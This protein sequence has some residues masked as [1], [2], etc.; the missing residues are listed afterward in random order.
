MPRRS[1]RPPSRRR[2][3]GW[4]DRYL[5]EVKQRF[6]NEAEPKRGWAVTLLWTSETPTAESVRC[7]VLGAIYRAC[8][9]RKHGSPRTLGQMMEQEGFAAL[10]AGVSPSLA[11]DQLAAAR[12]VIDR[13]R[14]SPHL[15]VQ[16]ACL[17]GDEAAR[18]VG[19]PPLGLPSR[20]GF[21]LAIAEAAQRGVDP[22]ARLLAA[23]GMQT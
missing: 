7:E 4:T 16:F 19:Y 17:Y 6:Q 21:A 5:T 22:K 12:A 11:E 20:A 9:I 23:L 18:S 1:P 8:W 2:A 3:R 13:Q 15:P 14:D 10:F